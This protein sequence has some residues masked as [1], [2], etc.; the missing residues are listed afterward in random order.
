[1]NSQRLGP[2]FI[3]HILLS[4]VFIIVSQMPAPLTLPMI[5]RSNDAGKI[6]FFSWVVTSHLRKHQS[7]PTVRYLQRSFRRLP[8]TSHISSMFPVVFATV[9]L[10]KSPLC[11]DPPPQHFHFLHVCIPNSSYLGQTYF[12]YK[13]SSELPFK[14]IDRHLEQN[15]TSERH[16]KDRFWFNE[17][18]H[19]PSKLPNY[20]GWPCVPKPW[21]S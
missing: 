1:M 19:H 3:Y 8:L 15:V 21:L 20:I 5:M 12:R 9:S 13:H 2:V 4:Q 6:M 16:K 11:K 18:L 7:L 17:S 14:L 10:C